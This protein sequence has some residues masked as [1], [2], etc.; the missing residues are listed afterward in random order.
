MSHFQGSGGHQKDVFQR[1]TEPGE[2]A[3]H[4]KGNQAI[5]DFGGRVTENV[6]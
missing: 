3:R 6:I 5:L 2:V 1:K 4:L